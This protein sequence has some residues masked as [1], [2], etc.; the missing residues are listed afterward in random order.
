MNPDELQEAL[1]EMIDRMISDLS[2][3]E[4]IPLRN[5]S[6]RQLA[7]L[8]KYARRLIGLGWARS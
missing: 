1:E 4:G 6:E 2:D 3:A 7:R 8:R 5:R